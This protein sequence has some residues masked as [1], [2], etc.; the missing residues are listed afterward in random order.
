MGAALPRPNACEH[1]V[2][3]GSG[4]GRPGPYPDSER[5]A[6]ARDGGAAAPRSYRWGPLAP[7]TP[8]R[9][10]RS[11][12]RPRTS[13]DRLEI[14][15][16]I[17]RLGVVV[18]EP[19]GDLPAEHRPLGVGAEVDAGAVGRRWTERVQ[20]RERLVSDR[21][22]RPTWV[23]AR[24]G[25]RV[26]LAMAAV[27]GLEPGGELARRRLPLRLRIVPGRLRRGRREWLRRP[28]GGSP[29]V[30]VCGPAQARPDP[31]AAESRNEPISSIGRVVAPGSGSSR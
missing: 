30:L 31:A 3:L 24:Q 2:A 20:P 18:L 12:S 11:S 15:L 16:L 4:P 14:V 28:V 10:A 19:V 29:P 1:R 17:D 6:R 5:T 13:L 25:R 27:E 22:S 7:E 23:V 8:R 9:D 21:G 26:A